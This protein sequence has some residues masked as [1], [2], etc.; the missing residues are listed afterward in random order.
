MLVICSSGILVVLAF[1]CHLFVNQ[2]GWK[3]G[4][5]HWPDEY[6]AIGKVVGCFEKQ[7]GA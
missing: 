4:H 3:A 5:Y 6:R 1:K 2:A 7:T